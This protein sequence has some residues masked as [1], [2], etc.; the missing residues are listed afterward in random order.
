VFAMDAT[1][2]KA[3]GSL[4]SGTGNTQQA[5]LDDAQLRAP[6]ENGAV[7][8]RQIGRPSTLPASRS[9]MG[10]PGTFPNGPAAVEDP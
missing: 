9:W 5:A 8:E 7:S 10:W 6:H 3:G 1:G 2:M 4:A